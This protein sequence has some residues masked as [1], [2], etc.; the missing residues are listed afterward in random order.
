MLYVRLDGRTTIVGPLRCAVEAA[1]ILQQMMALNMVNVLPSPMTSARIPPRQ[2]F[3][4][5]LFRLL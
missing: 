4:D 5:F 1:E 3:D 2:G